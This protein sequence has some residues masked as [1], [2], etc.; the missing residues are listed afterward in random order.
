MY[1]L[2]CYRM[3]VLTVL[4]GRGTPPCADTRSVCES[5]RRVNARKCHGG[6]IAPRRPV[7]KEWHFAHKRLVSYP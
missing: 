1:Y 2:P 7:S 4:V 3:C 5:G 6:G